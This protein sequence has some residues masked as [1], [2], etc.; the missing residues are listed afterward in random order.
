L[1]GLNSINAVYIDVSDADQV[2][3]DHSYFKG[4]PVHKNAA[5]KAMFKDILTGNS[6]E[7]L[8]TFVPSENYFRL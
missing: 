4:T 2:G 6:V 5:L 7:K 8:L 1:K 3:R